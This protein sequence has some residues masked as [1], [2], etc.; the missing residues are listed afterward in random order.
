M[1]MSTDIAQGGDL[2]VVSDQTNRITART[3]PLQNRP[4]GQITD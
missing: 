3:H 2:A 1:L 4:F